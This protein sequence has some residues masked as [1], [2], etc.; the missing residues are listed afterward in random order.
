MNKKSL[1]ICG[2]VIG[3]VL[4][5]IVMPLIPS[6]YKVPQENYG[7]VLQ[8]SFA[9]FAVGWSVLFLSIL[10][11]LWSYK[12]RNMNV[13][14]VIAGLLMLLLAYFWGTSTGGY[15]YSTFITFAVAPVLLAVGSLFM[16]LKKR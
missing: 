8:I 16:M 14:A 9:T 3:L 2:I 15:S 12:S 1:G 10:L 7:Q 4:M 13:A 11:V 5:V 6:V